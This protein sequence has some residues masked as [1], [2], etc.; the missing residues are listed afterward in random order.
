MKHLSPDTCDRSLDRRCYGVGGM[1][2][3]DERRKIE[4]VVGDTL[5]INRLRG[6]ENPRAV[7]LLNSSAAMAEQPVLRLGIQQGGTH[8]S[9]ATT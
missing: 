6:D 7:P 2:P 4:A 5:K 1:P 9:K 3:L 8:P